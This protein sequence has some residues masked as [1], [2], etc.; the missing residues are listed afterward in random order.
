MTASYGLPL[1]IIDNNNVY[2]IERIYNDTN[3]NTKIIRH[4]DTMLSLNNVLGC[5][6]M[7][8]RSMEEIKLIIIKMKNSGYFFNDYVNLLKKSN[9]YLYPT[10]S[11]LWYTSI[12]KIKK[13]ILD[14][15]NT[16]E[17]YIVIN[18]MNTELKKKIDKQIIRYALEGNILKLYGK[19]KFTLSILRKMISKQLY[20][21]LDDIYFE[22]YNFCK[23]YIFIINKKYI[24]PIDR[25]F[26]NK[27]YLVIKYKSESK[28]Q[29]D[30]GIMPLNTFL[31]L[32]DDIVM[33]Y[34]AVNIYG[35]I[36]YEK[37]KFVD[38]LCDIDELFYNKIIIRPYHPFESKYRTPKEINI[39]SPMHGVLLKDYNISKIEPILDYIKEVWCNNNPQLYGYIISHLSCIIKKP[40]IKTNVIVIIYG[41][42]KDNNIL[43]LDNIIK[44]LMGSLCGLKINML[45]MIKI[46]GTEI[47][48]NK[49]LLVGK[50]D[51][52]NIFPDAHSYLQKFI[53]KKITGA[54]IFYDKH[55]KYDFDI[56][57]NLFISCN[58]LDGLNID[59]LNNDYILLKYNEKYIDDPYYYQNLQEC[60]DDKH[61][62]DMLF[63]YL[64]NY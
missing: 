64:Y 3:C 37:I 8:K 6:N 51:N 62:M 47:L 14:T 57:Y 26:K 22:I 21:N 32:Y 5:I 18:D 1:Q 45:D 44:H 24:N 31:I 11:E 7:K 27:K 35:D 50:L 56:F 28:K 38:V 4:R 42:K 49:I 30:Y 48:K 59:P 53:N 52:F 40:W 9:V 16:E 10:L 39:Y 55:D 36:K 25:E 43:L 60:C 46:A 61:N 12:D 20:E 63:S 13:K 58:N 23:K 17:S 19:K 41:K 2:N 29:R 33:Y 34:R 54:Q 15:Q